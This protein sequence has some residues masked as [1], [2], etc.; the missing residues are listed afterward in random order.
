MVVDL[1][2]QESIGMRIVR[3]CATENWGTLAGCF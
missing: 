3:F 1:K 2:F